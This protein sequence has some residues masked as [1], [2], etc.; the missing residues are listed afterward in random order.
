M[1]KQDNDSSKNNSATEAG[2]HLQAQI[3]KIKCDEGRPNCHKCASTGRTCDGYELPPENGT[4]TSSRRRLL[5]SPDGS[6]PST[7][8]SSPSP[9][10][11]LRPK[12]T[13]PDFSM[14]EHER[15]CMSYWRTFGARAVYRA[16]PVREWVQLALQFSTIEP[17]VMLAITACA[18]VQKSVAISMHKAMEPPT[19]ST[20]NV[21]LAMVQFGKATSALR[22]YIHKA[23][24][25]NACLEPV[26]LCA[27][28]FL[29]FEIGR[30]KFQNA[31]AHLNFARKIVPLQRL[32]AFSGDAIEEFSHLFSAIESSASVTGTPMG[33]DQDSHFHSRRTLDPT[34]PA[35]FESLSE[36]KEHLNILLEA[37]EEARNELVQLADEL[38]TSEDRSRLHPATAFM[39]KHCLSRTIVPDCALQARIQ[40]LEGGFK[41]WMLAFDF[42]TDST[43]QHSD[44]ETYIFGATLRLQYLVA[45]D[46]LQ[47]C[48]SPCEADWD[49]PGS[50]STFATTLDVIERFLA[51]TATS[52]PKGVS[53]PVPPYAPGDM[54]HASFG[55]EPTA[56]PALAHIAFKCRNTSIRRRALRMLLTARRREGLGHSES[57]AWF[58]SVIVDAEEQSA[59]HHLQQRGVVPGKTLM[60]EQVPEA[61]RIMFMVAC[62]E[63]E[64][65]TR[66]I[67]A[68]FRHEDDGKLELRQWIGQKEPIV[69]EEIDTLVMQYHC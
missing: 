17:A 45:F 55:L 10:S 35:A 1:L 3:R 50:D 33:L 51:L 21:D 48:C 43:L 53:G 26:L 23:V 56:L 25:G 46:T 28:L 27:I 40:G 13:S 12:E 2:G 41:R 11:V 60:S 61:A 34:I 15:N 4:S 64:E 5:P 18:T 59:R 66:V 62:G 42:L 6:S 68:R 58:I 57:A 9:V 30:A 49:T 47:H 54:R 7:S 16:T 31:L 67:C 24:N 44:P 36:A 29:L 38:I 22:R 69:F 32:S 20:R 52:M 14:T 63:T 8:G 39:I 37:S 19:A 65:T